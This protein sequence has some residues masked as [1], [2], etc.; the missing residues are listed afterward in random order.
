MCLLKSDVGLLG[1]TALSAETPEKSIY[2]KMNPNFPLATA[3]YNHRFVENPLSHYF[4]LSTSF[5]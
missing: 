3:L 5:S 4:L 1:Q 2:I